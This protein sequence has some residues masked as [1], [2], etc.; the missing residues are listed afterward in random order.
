[1]RVRV[2]PFAPKTYGQLQNCS[3]AIQPG[4]TFC[5]ALRRDLIPQEL[6]AEWPNNSGASKTCIELDEAQARRE[7]CQMGATRPP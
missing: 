6:R 3:R 4:N 7:S 5:M 1:M 2:P